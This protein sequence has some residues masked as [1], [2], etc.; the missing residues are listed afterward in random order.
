MQK[1]TRVY[2]LFSRSGSDRASSVIVDW[3]DLMH[4]ELVSWTPK[5]EL[6][7]A[8]AARLCYRDVSAVE[9]LRNLS[10]PEIDH[11]LDVIL[12]SG[13]LSVVEHINFTFAVDGVSRVLTHQ[14]VRHR[15]GIAF[16]QQS[17]RYASVDDAEI[18][19]PRSVGATPELAAEFLAVARAAMGLY[20]RM[21]ELGIPNE[22]ARFALPQAVATRLVM[23]VN[24][25]ELMHIYRL[26]ACLRSQWEMRALVNAMKR[27]IRRVSPR[28]A[29][30]LKIKCFAQ[31][32]CDEAVMCS[33]LDGKMPR[34]QAIFHGYQ[35]YTQN[36]YHDLAV[37]V[38]EEEP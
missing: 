13:H 14:L 7:A 19:V 22:D 35:E 20:R 23:T 15:V 27:E 17:Q 38:G 16:S 2:R 34:K 32:Y 18:V 12:S 6:L 4:V 37:S 36:Y 26:D 30:E 10:Q 21:L 24:L 33:Q 1:F 31:G 3:G 29:G 11:L 8:A 5:P 9:L 28:L 25:R